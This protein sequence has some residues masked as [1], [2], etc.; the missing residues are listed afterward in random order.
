MKQNKKYIYLA[1]INLRIKT[2]C[3]AMVWAEIPVYPTI[4]KAARRQTGQ[5]APCF[6]LSTNC[7]PTSLPIRGLKSK[8]QHK[9]RQETVTLKGCNN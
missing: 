9:T 7:R 6:D 8:Q 5:L 1:L 3:E 2:L 4:T